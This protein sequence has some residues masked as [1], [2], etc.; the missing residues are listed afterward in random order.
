MIEQDRYKID[1][2]QIGNCI[3]VRRESYTNEL[4]KMYGYREGMF[5]EARIKK[6]RSY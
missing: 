2:S 1:A 6:Q 4:I 5:E 3:K